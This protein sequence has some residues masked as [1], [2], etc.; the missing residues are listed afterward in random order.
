MVILTT[1]GRVDIALR[2]IKIKPLHDETG[3]CDETLFGNISLA[4]C[5]FEMICKGKTYGEL[6]EEE[7]A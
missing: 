2:N 3:A 1:V 7:N 6:V 5:N 4:H